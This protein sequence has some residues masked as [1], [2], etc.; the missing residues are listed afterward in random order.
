MKRIFLAAAMSL[1]IPC[2]SFATGTIETCDTLFEQ[3]RIELQVYYARK[4]IN[5][6]LRNIESEC[7]IFHRRCVRAV[8][9]GKPIPTFKSE[10]GDTP[11]V[12][13][14]SEPEASPECRSKF[15][16]CRKECKSNGNTLT[17]QEQCEKDF[18][19]CTK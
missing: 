2:A 13:E 7:G 8:N 3:C 10:S 17:C 11:V 15:A 1:M 9:E 19:S 14:K 4:H 5:K 12:L 18:Y 16:Q 6:E